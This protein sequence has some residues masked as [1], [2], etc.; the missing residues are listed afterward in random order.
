MKL[1]KRMLAYLGV[2]L[3]ATILCFAWTEFVLP[4]IPWWQNKMDES[5]A[6]L[7]QEAFKHNGYVSEGYP[8]WT[9]TKLP[10]LDG[11]RIPEGWRMTTE[12]NAADKSKAALPQA[13]RIAV[14]I[15]DTAGAQIARGTLF[16]TEREAVDFK[17]TLSEIVGFSVEVFGRREKLDI[18]FGEREALYF[19]CEASGSGQ[20]T[21][22]LC[23]KLADGDASL[24]LWFPNCEG[25]AYVALLD[26]VEA[27]AA[28]F[29]GAG[30][31]QE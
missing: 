27:I 18:A 7:R 11:F 19:S 26:R 1:M 3:A 31:A 9:E 13:A 20:Q 23:L 5:E 15:T 4:H 25:D 24:Y 22:L 28:S 16:P 2:L 21:E 29:H 17:G 10:G 30:T 12:T 14:T 8:G 6:W